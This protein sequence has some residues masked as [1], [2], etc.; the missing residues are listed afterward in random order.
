MNDKGFMLA[1]ERSRGYT[2]QNIMDTDYADDIALQA[3]TS[4]QAETPLHNLERAAGGI[5]LHANTDKTEYVCLNQIVTI[6]TLNSCSLKIVEKFLYLGSS[7]SSTEK[8]INMRLKKA[9]TAIDRVSVIWKSNLTDKIK[10]SFFSKQ[11]S[12]D[13]AI[14]MHYMDANKTYGEKA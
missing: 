7:V 6:S 3:N 13:T 2:S 12:C 11:R 9:G 8:D 5:G 10:R 14:W 4:P 1:K